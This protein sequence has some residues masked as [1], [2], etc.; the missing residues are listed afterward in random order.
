M[1]R[2]IMKKFI[3]FTI[4]SVLT[5]VLLVGCKSGDK[6]ERPPVVSAKLMAPTVI[7]EVLEVKKDG[8]QILVN[9]AD[10]NVKGQIWVSIDEKTSFFE[11]ISKGTSIPYSNV[12]R[13]FVVGNHVE[14]FIEGG[15]A[16]SYP[17][18]G[19]ATAVYVNETK[20]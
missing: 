1:R 20:K 17:M 4:V 16:E 9:S 14:I 11:S 18:Q 10:A 2:D 15:V 19:T 7:G 6:S 5:V 3:V 13:K 12:S 8:K